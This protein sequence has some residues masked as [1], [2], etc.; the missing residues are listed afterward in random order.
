ME[1][2]WA[3][4][5]E[6][7]NTRPLTMVAVG[8]TGKGKSSTLNT[9]VKASRNNNFT[10]NVDYFKANEGHASVTSN[11][12]SCVIAPEGFPPCRLV[13]TIGLFDTKLTKTQK[14]DLRL[15]NESSLDEEHAMVLAQFLEVMD[16]CKDGIDAFLFVVKAT[17]RATKEEDET[18]EIIFRYLGWNMLEYVIFVVTGKD[19]SSQESFEGWRT[20][21]C[22]ILQK[23]GFPL[24]RVRDRFIFVDNMNPTQSQAYELLSLIKYVSDMNQGRPYTPV[25]FEKAQ[26]DLEKEKQRIKNKLEQEFQTKV[27]EKTKPIRE[28][29]EKEIDKL[30]HQITKNE[31]DARQ[32]REDQVAERQKY[33]AEVN[34]LKTS[35]EDEKRRLNQ[36]MQ[37]QIKML[38]S[39]KVDAYEQ[40][41]KDMMKK[42]M[43]E[44]SEM[45][46]A[47][48]QE[49]QK[50][51][52]A[53]QQVKQ[54]ETPWWEKV[55]PFA[56]TVI[57]TFFGKKA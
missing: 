32:L 9:M 26:R 37:Q 36:E 43:Q 30:Q 29:H 3:N 14:D 19:K 55:I 17:D 31:S 27:D 53:W 7:Y 24:E 4:Y 46:R 23:R 33:Q 12:A 13:D 39:R 52:T 28:R 49:L 48:M 18:I 2:G 20:H 57:S 56:A 1:N 8:K 16:L 54:E 44:I 25:S 11:I 47:T 34:K 40:E 21:I 41:W 22:G 51:Q 5:L 10:P 6:Q 45:H 42:Q 38:E 15:R 35:L 50:A